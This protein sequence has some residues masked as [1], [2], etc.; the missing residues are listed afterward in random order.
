MS[1]HTT[2]IKPHLDRSVDMLK[3]EI[4]QQLN[5]R[6][7]MVM[8]QTHQRSFKLSYAL[9]PLAL[10][11]ALWFSIM[12]EPGLTADEEALYED[13]ELLIVEGD[14]EF[15]D[16]MDVSSWLLEEEVTEAS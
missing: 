16:E 10:V 6:R 11:F 1:E 14:L 9:A 12:P 2:D 15:L 7:N 3:P 4:E 8:H 5:A 13:I